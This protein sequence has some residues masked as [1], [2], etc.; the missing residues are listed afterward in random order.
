MSALYFCNPGKFDVDAMLTFGVNAKEDDTAIGYFGTGFK[1]AVAITLR[2]GGSV[3]VETCGARYVFSKRQTE[4]RGKSFELVCC[5]GKDTGFTTRLGVNW[6]PWM[7]FREFHC[8]A[9]DEGGC[10]S[11]TR[12]DS[13][14][15][16]RVDCT[17]IFKAYQQ[18]DRYFVSTPELFSNGTVS[19][20]RGGSDLV[21]YKGVAVT[22][23]PRP[24]EFSYNI[25]ARVDLT[26]D[27]MAK[28]DWQCFGLIRDAIQ[29][30]DDESFLRKAI[31]SGEHFEAR[32]SFY[33]ESKYSETFVQ[34]ARELS[35]TD[36]GCSDEARKF[37][38]KVTE[39]DRCWPEIALSAVQKTMLL[40]AMDFLRDIQV[41]IDDFPILVV[42]GLGE[43][44]MGRAL[45]GC[46]Y[47]SELPFQ[48]G[49]KQ[50]ASTLLEEW[51]HCKH[52]C[53]DFD[54]K[55]QTWLFDKVLSIGEEMR[56]D[57]L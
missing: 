28:Y 34:V 11:A 53:E 30:A 15:I 24:A 27:R 42:R 21:Y 7:A 45:E 1:Y 36:A 33:A 48:L 14:T 23:L 39:K 29:T 25:L 55:M 4:I 46:V 20:H 5:N 31:R 50:V 16:I 9:M 37:L 49:T 41:T 18:R 13:E 19:V 10:T 26:E 44:V 56:G 6:E 47:L 35:K 12:V 8:N 43:G 2:L 32:T 38:S 57:P 52:G 3:V 51:V 22:A 40:R 54:R 17:D